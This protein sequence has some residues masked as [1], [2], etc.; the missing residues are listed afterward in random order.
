MT[1][2]SYG[3]M[4]TLLTQ[5]R[6]WGLG[7]DQIAILELALKLLVPVVYAMDLDHW[8]QAVSILVGMIQPLHLVWSLL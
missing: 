6:M 4:I 5:A 2:I 1:K 8:R 3:L 7:K